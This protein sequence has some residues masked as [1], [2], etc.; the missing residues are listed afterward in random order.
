MNNIKTVSLIYGYSAK[1]AGDFAITLGA[2]DMLLNT[3]VNVKLF[4]RYCE[5]DKDF[6]TAK[7]CIEKRY[8]NTIE[9][10]E[11]PFCLDRSDHFLKTL[12]NYINGAF[13]IWGIKK[14]L[15]FNSNLL[16][17]DFLI[18]NGGNLFRCNSFIDYARLQALLYPLQKAINNNIP[19]IVF[20]QSASKLN[21]AGQ[22]L[23]FPILEK[24]KC[25]FIREKESY[26]YLSRFIPSTTL[27][28][29]IDLAFFINKINLT[30]ITHKEKIA[31]TLRFHT[32]GDISYLNKYSIDS[33][34][35][36]MG[37]LVEYF[38]NKYEI[39]IIIQSNKDEIKSKEFAHRYGLNYIKSNDIEE[40]IAI[41]RNIK[42]L[43][44]MRLHS[45]ILALS[46]GTPCVGT[47]IKE[48]GLKNPGV[49]KYFNMPY[50][51]LDDGSSIIN[52]E[53]IDN[54]KHLLNNFNSIS[55]RILNQIEIEK[56]KFTNELK[57][58]LQ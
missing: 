2:L 20:P 47:F 19:F 4:S 58:L 52:E 18:F 29:T 43:I 25:I 13:T 35:K 27:Y 1:N 26:E 45:I 49:M 46:V 12:K 34:F 56:T 50:K 22:K 48:W 23:L 55:Q 54:I 37:Y 10:Y 32:V 41:Y 44:G 8:G 15:K 17:S 51:I 9:I 53:L 57:S 16:H 3:G 42:L 40:L 30:N 5:K 24:A 7:T 14:N 33:I 38:K 36:H 6:W 28:Q 11:S 21:L 39:I 31:I